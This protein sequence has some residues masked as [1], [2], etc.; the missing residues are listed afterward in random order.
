MHNLNVSKTDYFG[1]LIKK[2]A[3]KYPNIELDVDSFLDSIENVKDLGVALG[4]NL[5]KARI[6]NTDNSKGKSGGYRLI[7]YLL[8]T[9][10]NLTLVYIYSKAELATINESIL[11]K[12]VLDSFNKSK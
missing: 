12:I 3:K 1:K 10:N 9:E 7:S 11:D 5:Y 2:L 6:K 8:L 4:N